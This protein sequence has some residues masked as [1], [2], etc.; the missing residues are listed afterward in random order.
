MLKFYVRHGMIFD[1]IQEII[2]FKQKKVLEKHIKFSTQKRN[3]AKN[4]FEKDF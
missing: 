1:K 3:K 4:G 2:S